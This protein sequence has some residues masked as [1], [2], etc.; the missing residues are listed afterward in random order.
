M[1]NKYFISFNSS[2]KDLE[3][4]DEDALL[5]QIMFWAHAIDKRLCY[6]TLKISNDLREKLELLSIRLNIFKS[7]FNY[8]NSAFAWAVQMKELCEKA[9]ENPEEFLY[10][11]QEKTTTTITLEMFD[12]FIKTRRSVRNFNG[13]PVEDELII[14]ILEYASWAP[15]SCNEQ[16]L[17]Y[18][19]IK[20]P[21]NKEI[22]N[23]CGL[24]SEL[25]G[26]VI[27]VLADLRL[28]SDTDIECTCHDSGA[29]IQNTLLACHYFGLGACYISDTVLNTH[30]VRDVLPVKEY[31][32]VTALVA[33]G[34]YD[35][36]PLTPQRIPIEKF[37]RYC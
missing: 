32:K 31:E 9:I 23:R 29:A 26:C 6:D 36:L 10:P 25:A 22:I 14:K 19:I 12:S 28:Y 13:Q 33:V 30:M 16:A 2:I 4:L 21:K 7:K 8:N 37:I 20:D 1:N 15:S 18:V 11:S 5:T 17:R 24:R 27:A 35:K 34:H 3:K